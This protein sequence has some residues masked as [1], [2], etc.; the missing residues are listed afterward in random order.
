MLS[1]GEAAAEQGEAVAQVQHGKPLACYARLDH[2][3]MEGGK[4]VAPAF[5]STASPSSP[6]RSATGRMRSGLQEQ[7]SE[8]G[9]QVHGRVQCKIHGAVQCSMYGQ[10]LR[11]AMHASH[12]HHGR[13]GAHRKQPSVS[14]YAT[15]PAPV[16]RM[17]EVTLYMAGQW[18]YTRV[19]PPCSNSASL[20]PPPPPTSVLAADLGGDAQRVAQLRLAGAPLPKDLGD[21]QGRHMRGSHG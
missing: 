6:N 18:S 12:H 5:T 3:S 16:G 9:A 14:M 21:L 10:V 8:Q 15:L 2:R 17:Q 20:P 7:G 13:Q 1:C 11:H 19:P 4:A